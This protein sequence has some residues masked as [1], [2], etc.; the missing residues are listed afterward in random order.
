MNTDA[1]YAKML[2]SEKTEEYIFDLN[3]TDCIEKIAIFDIDRLGD[4]NY[5]E[6]S[7]NADVERS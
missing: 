3:R 5:M 1:E 7:R 2:K 4:I 6:E